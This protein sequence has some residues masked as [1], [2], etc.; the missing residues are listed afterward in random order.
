[1]VFHDTKPQFSKSTNMSKFQ[2]IQGPGRFLLKRH[3]K[4]WWLCGGSSD[5]L[6]VSSSLSLSLSL[7]PFV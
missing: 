4:A 7:S 1:M 5:F 3:I 6:Q 2:A